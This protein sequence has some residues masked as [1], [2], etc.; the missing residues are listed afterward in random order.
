M[1]RAQKLIR[2][3]ERKAKRTTNDTLTDLRELSDILRKGKHPRGRDLLGP[4]SGNFY[5]CAMVS[6]LAIKRMRKK[7]KSN[8]KE[9]QWH[10]ERI[11]RLLLIARG[12]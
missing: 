5:Q 7:T 6:N 8:V 12:K 4:G 2:Q 1:T 9:W 11:Q 10:D 3:E